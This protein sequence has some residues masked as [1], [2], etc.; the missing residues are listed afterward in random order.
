MLLP[1]LSLG[2][3]FMANGPST[4]PRLTQVKSQPAQQAG[5]QYQQTVESPTG[6]T[7]KATLDAINQLQLPYPYAGGSTVTLTMRSRGGDTH[8]YLSISKGMFAPSFTGGTAQI[9]FDNAPAVTYT[10]SA[11][12]NGRG[13]LLFIDDTARLLRQLRTTRTM[14]VQLNVPGQK[15]ATLQFSATPL[16]WA[17]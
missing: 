4:V 5:W 3:L 6:T 17:H 16:R 15:L 7:Y 9:R 8:A 1:L 12:A 13:N 11:A 14:V 10:L 2:L